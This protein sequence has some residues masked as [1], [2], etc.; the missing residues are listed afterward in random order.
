MSSRQ[1]VSHIF[2]LVRPVFARERRILEFY[3]HTGLTGATVW[4]GSRNQ[5]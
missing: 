2:G 4:R 3:G 5:Y 1:L